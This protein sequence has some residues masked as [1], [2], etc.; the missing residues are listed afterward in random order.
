[1]AAMGEKASEVALS[2]LHGL[3][4]EHFL[5]KLR[6]GD[7]EKGDLN[8]IRQFLKDNSIDCYGPGN[9]TLGSIADELP[10]FDVEDMG[11]SPEMG[12][13][14]GAGRTIIPLIAP[15]QEHQTTPKTAVNVSNDG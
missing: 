6:S 5:K 2:T 3:L 4:A 10:Q 8:V 15:A 1:M 9:E 14:E 11:C 13:E 12:L 7:L